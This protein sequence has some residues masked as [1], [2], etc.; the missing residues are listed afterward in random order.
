[1]KPYKLASHKIWSVNSEERSNILKLDWNEATIPP[2]PKVKEHLLHILNEPTFFNLYPTTYN[3]RLLELLSGYVGLPKDNIQYFGS[4][5]ALHE[6]ICKVY[7]SVGDPVMILGPSYDNFRLTCQANGAEVYY[8]NFTEE[9]KFDS[10]KFEND[11]EKR[12]RQ[13]YIS[14]TRIIQQEICILKNI[15][16]IY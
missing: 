4:S 5:D 2:S 6:Y 14:V 8:S 15:L 10:S 13:S 12:N 3:D 1:M 7:I 9:F 16:N 11:I